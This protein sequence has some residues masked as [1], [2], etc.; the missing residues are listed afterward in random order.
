MYA[1]GAFIYPYFEDDD[2]WVHATGAKYVALEKDLKDPM[3]LF[4]Y[5]DPYPPGFAILLGTLHQTS[6]SLMWTMKFFN[7]LIISLGI[8]FFYFFAKEFIKNRNKAFFAT[9][10]FTMV[11]CYLSHFIWAHSYIVTMF[12][13]LMYSFLM[14]KQDPRW[15]YS[16]ALIYTGVL[17]IQPTQAIKLS[18][19]LGLYILI[20]SILKKRIQ[21]SSFVALIS[22]G[23]LSLLW[24]YNRIGEMFGS[25]RLKTPIFEIQE[26]NLLT[27]LIGKLAKSFPT[28]SGTATRA[29]TFDDFFVAKSQNMI[30]NP[31]GVGIVLSLLL[32]FSLIIIIMSYKSLLK[33]KNHWLVV[34]VFWLFFTFLGINSVTF[35]LPVGLFAF[36]FWM[37]FAIPLSLV[38]AHGFSFIVRFLKQIGVPKIAT[39][40][41]LIILIFL[42]S[43]QQK[44]TVNTAMWGP[45]QAWTSMEE[46][47]AYVWLKG[48]PP[49][50][51]VFAY[52]SDEHILG[53]D[54]FSC[55]WCDDIIEFRKDL[56]NK[57]APQLYNWLKKERYEYLIFDG[58]AYRE[59][60][61]VFGINET[62]EILP[63]RLDEIGRHGRFQVAHQ[64]QGAVIFRII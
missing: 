59:L 51:K 57:N 45:G 38:A 6:P 27:K 43:G 62:N 47:S 58:K 48:L 9:V 40:S 11:P 61:S 12:F 44:Y 18:I 50:T 24:W 30:N 20:D 54:K 23:L 31:I 5:M 35:R 4:K 14:I 25:Q 46:I 3:N 28:N 19:M 42:T 26:T 22:G 1:K 10:I 32:I 7:A 53:F 33:E 63:Q 34:S 55:M 29:Y 17:L 52:S 16:S 2:P 56:L 60:G 15:K 36:R 41:L 39:I 49:D 21:W 13:P 37:L 64:T 8:L